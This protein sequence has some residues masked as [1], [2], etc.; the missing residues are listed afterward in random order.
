MPWTRSAGLLMRTSACREMNAWAR[1]I[2]ASNGSGTIE[3]AISVLNL[4]LT[5]SDPTD[6][7]YPAATVR[8]G[9]LVAWFGSEVQPIVAIPPI[10]L[11][12]A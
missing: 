6:L 3:D 5:A 1:L 10:D 2:A 4:A 7:P 8:Q 11:A 9:L 12:T